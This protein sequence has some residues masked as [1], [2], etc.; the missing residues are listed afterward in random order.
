MSTT[1][2]KTCNIFLDFLIILLGIIILIN[3]YSYIQIKILNK[4]YSS[5]FGYSVFEVQTGSMK[6]AIS[7]SDVIIVKS[8]KNPNVNDIITYKKN[9]DFITH[10][11]VEKS[12]N[13]YITKGDANNTRDSAI[14]NEDII[15]KVVH[16]LPRFGIIRKTI[17]NPIVILTLIITTVVVHFLFNRKKKSK[18]SIDKDELKESTPMEVDASLIDEEEIIDEEETPEEDTSEEETKDEE[19]EDYTQELI[20]ESNDL[21]NEIQS[22]EDLE[23][24]IVFRKI[25]VDADDLNPPAPVVEEEEEEEST[26]EVVEELENEDEE[27][28]TEVKLN[29]L[30]KRKK[31]FN[32]IL[33]K[34]MYFKEEEISELANIIYPSKF[35]KVNEASIKEKLL[36]IY[37]DGKYYNLVGNVDAHYNGKNMNSKLGK[38]ITSESEK[39]VKSYKGND[40]LY[41]A[42]VELIANMFITILYLENIFVSDLELDEKVSKYKA[43]IN[44]YLKGYYE[45]DKELTDAVKK[46]IVCERTYR[47]ASNKLIDSLKTNTFELEFNE[48]TTKKNIYALKLNHNINFSRLYSEY[49][50]DKT[51]DEGIVAEDKILV[52]INILLGRIATDILTCNTNNLYLLYMPESLYEKSNKLIKVK[53]ML[54]DEMVRNRVILVN[55]NEAISNN[56]KVIKQMKKKGFRFGLLVNEDDK[57]TIDKTSISLIDY[58][59]VDKKLDK[60]LKVSSVLKNNSE[61]NAIKENINDLIDVS[62]GVN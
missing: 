3:V 55:K 28:N 16:I 38:I 13:N 18:F 52:T 41:F 19:T 9:D 30:N 8:D 32:N 20:E 11:V 51:Y 1:I 24:T 7:P 57:K 47:S 53:S 43:T 6:P 49:I 23:K 60:K 59:F 50:I 40:K 12:G 5:F 61:I 46:L 14:T 37:I 44:K 56:K 29:Y 48:L 21:N 4:N 62:G 45:N 31:K 26:E 15:G 54:S 25:T 22:E 39:L 34:I 2:R 10:R 36:K 33:E 35:K 27:K 42:K 58:V 17:L